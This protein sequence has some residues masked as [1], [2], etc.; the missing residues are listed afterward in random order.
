MW[1]SSYI[2]YANLIHGKNAQGF[3]SATV[4]AANR[5]F[6]TSV[7]LREQA[8]QS[9]IIQTELMDNVVVIPIAQRANIEIYSGKMKNRKTPNSTVPGWWNITQWYFEP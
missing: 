4:D 2:N 6:K 9:A 1:D 8:E 3:S 5:L 7:D